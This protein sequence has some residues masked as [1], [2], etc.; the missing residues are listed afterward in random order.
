MR[1]IKKSLI[2]ITDLL[3]SLDIPFQIAGGLAAHAYGATRELWDIDLD[4]PEDKFELIKSHTQ[5]YIIYGPEIYADNH[6]HLLLMTLNHHDQLIDLGGAYNTKIFN[7][8]TKLWHEL[9]TDFS[10]IIEQEILGL[11]LPV[12]SRAELVAYKKILS[13]PV[14]LEDIAQIEAFRAI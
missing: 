3:K 2:W 11:T 13:R 4:I 9:I 1:D 5:K 7:P 12:I 10:T 8:E 6:W 14:D